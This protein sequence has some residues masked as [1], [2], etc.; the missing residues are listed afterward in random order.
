VGDLLAEGVMRAWIKAKRKPNFINVDFYQGVKGANGPFLTLDPDQDPA[1]CRWRLC[2]NAP[3]PGF[4]LVNENSTGNCLEKRPD[5]DPLGT[6]T[7]I[8]GGGTDPNSL[9][10]VYVDRGS[11]PYW[12]IRQSVDDNNNLSVHHE[13]KDNQTFVFDSGGDGDTQRWIFTKV[14]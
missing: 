14:S 8:F 5:R 12:V 3:A 1:S 6:S 13:F 11:D 4:M 10:I 9:E 2:Y 7:F